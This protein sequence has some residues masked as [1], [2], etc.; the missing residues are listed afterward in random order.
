[1]S[2]RFSQLTVGVVAAMVVG[3]CAYPLFYHIAEPAA[4]EPQLAASKPKPVETPP[5]EELEVPTGVIIDDSGSVALND[6]DDTADDS[7]AASA[8][9]D[10]W[11][12]EGEDE[13][14]LSVNGEQST[15]SYMPAR[16]E[17]VVEEAFSED[18]IPDDP[19]QNSFAPVSKGSRNGNMERNAKRLAKQLEKEETKSRREPFVRREFTPDR[20]MKPEQ[21]YSELAERV[22]A[23]LGQLDD[24]TV[25]KFMEEPANRLD[26]ATLYL[27]N[28]AGL[29]G[30]RAVAGKK[31]GTSLLSAL[32]SDLDWMTG[33]LYSGPT[34]KL[35]KA[36]ENLATIYARFSED[37]SDP[38][39]RRIATTAAL[40]F[41]R[42][43][44]GEK[45]LVDR[46]IYFYTSYKAG[47]LNVLF[48]SLQYWETRLVTGCG[49]LGGWG[50]VRSLTWQR[51]NVRL[52]V[53][54][55][56]GACNQI[57]YRLRNVAGDSVFSN[58]YLAPI[59][60][61]T[62]NTTAWAHRE[63]GGVCGACS[64]YGA[65]AALAQGLPAM[66]MGEPGHCA[67]TVRVAGEWKMSY[68]I[69]WEHS[70]HKAFWGEREWDFLI[71][72][73]KLYEDRY[74]TLVS[75][76]MVAMGD[77]LAARKK[78]LAASNCYENAVVAQPLNW[79][80]WLRYAGYLKAKSPENPGKWAE[81]HNR[82]IETLAPQF[83]NASATLL[84]KYVYPTLIKNVKDRRELNK[85]F[86]AFF[87][88][89]DTMGTNRWD[90]S[91]LLTAQMASCSTPKEQLDYMRDSLKT[92]MAKPDYAGS[93]LSWGLDFV[94]G[95]KGTDADSLALQ[96]EFT[97]LVVKSLSRTRTNRK[98]L[99]ATWRTLG[100]AINTAAQNRDRK[101]F[102]AIGKLAYRKCKKNFPKNKFKFKSFPGKVV[103]ATGLISTSTTLS[104]GQVPQSCLH[105]G[106][107]QRHGGSMPCKFEGKCAITVL[108]EAKS[109]ISGVVCLFHD[110]IKKDRDYILEA[111]DDGQNW[112]K[113][114]QGGEVN[115]AI[116]RFDCRD[117]KLATKNV[118]VR[119]DGDKYEP[120]IVGMYVYGKPI[121]N[122]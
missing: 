119:R 25:W 55:Y 24:D 72:M 34:D 32:S 14:S 112:T 96:E 113:V 13:S 20:W 103:S 44:W 29:D 16:E 76:Q 101:I 50:S 105:W 6:G 74:N 27:V 98:E 18:D 39:A 38:V 40:E 116:L 52:P 68:S 92:L 82:I 117:K 62:N 15:D 77:F 115:G 118:R 42:E 66:T 93:V 36:L 49:G 45:E 59:Q 70:M 19:A 9:D 75:D 22:L 53:E 89:C 26:L 2:S 65:Y 104:P 121:R 85:M 122:K 17:F 100:E 46:Y 23:K 61:Y 30:L 4:P 67:Y 56:L 94:S 69:Y 78:M 79:P 8:E 73:Q 97:E 90:I 35:G 51:D 63:I 111:S 54:G 3:F 102:Q 84:S 64:H 10:S 71:L 88:K 110:A 86:A 83:H 47:K 60:K 58:E 7:G 95:I 107:L 120:T 41:A 114:C 109:T 81:L 37:M 5:S 106:V 57:S 108:M 31:M 21:V 12:F 87:D 43:G 80:A 11:M 48:D 99:D 91:R 33:L 1:M 28:R